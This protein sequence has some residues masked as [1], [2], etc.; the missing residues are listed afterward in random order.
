MIL[1]ELSFYN[2]TALQPRILFRI[3]PYGLVILGLYICSYPDQYAEQT[4]WSSQ[5]ASLAQIIF[6]KGAHLSRYYAGLGAQMICFGVILSPSMRRILSHPALLWLGSIS[7]P[8]Y[9]LHGPL[10]RSVLV[11]L[12]YLPMSVGFNPAVRADG[13][14]DPESYIPTPSPLRLAVILVIFFAFL[15]YVVQQWAKHVEPRIGGITAAFERFSRSWGR[16]TMWS[17][18]QKAEI[19]PIKEIYV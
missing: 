2:L 7:F 17:P 19:L 10:M 8:L 15:L 18:K 11:Y 16:S 1:A 12:L 4:A 14:P 9:L 5:L 3:L 13:T 6:P